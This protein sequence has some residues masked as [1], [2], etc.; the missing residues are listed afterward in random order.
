[1]AGE[2]NETRATSGPGPEHGAP[3]HRV[4]ATHRLIAGWTIA[5]AAGSWMLEAGYSQ[6]GSA[7]ASS[8]ATAIKCSIYAV[9]W[10]P[11]LYG[12][13]VLSDRLPIQGRHDVPRI[14][15]HGTATLAA[16][17][18]WGAVTYY[19]CLW[20]VPGW[21]PLGLGRMYFTTGFGVVYVFS[22]VLIICHILR[23]VREQQ[24][25][26][27]AT[28]V[29]AEGAARARIQVLFM[30]LRP[31]FLCN[32]LHAVSAL[33]AED[34]ARAIELLRRLRALLEYAVRTESRMEV[35]L[36][37]ELATVR[38]Y[39]E[40]Q[41]L[42]FSDRL[43]VRWAIDPATTGAAVPTLMLQPI[44]ENAVK[45]SVET[46]S[47]TCVVTIEAV[48]QGRELIVRVADE[49]AG[50]GASG[51]RGA[52]LGL[53]NARERLRY[54]YGT[55]QELSLTANPAGKGTVV[56][57]RLPFRTLGVAKGPRVA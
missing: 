18:T 9:A 44:V 40:I 53:A 2:A 8:V 10:A 13:V 4:A 52:G 20:L 28:L 14:T 26:E 25:R 29:L 48:R 57:V 19:T 12:A 1:M 54:L 47:R 21:K 31:H 32:T 24:V 37:E 51:R 17:L 22:T 7:R 34:G 15:I 41:Q 42:R 3:L 43:G 35:P 23:Q 33:L 50:P 27:V 6:I 30:E 46:T 39:L 49:G 16:V 56:E 45:F 36:D 55:N 11:L 5:Y 38:V